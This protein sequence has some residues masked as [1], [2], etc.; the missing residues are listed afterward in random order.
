[1][2]S[3]GIVAGTKEKEKIWREKYTIPKKN[4]YD[5]D[6]FD[7]IADNPD[8]DIVYVVLP[9]SMHADFLD[10]PPKP[11]SMRFVKNQWRLVS[12]NVRPLSTPVK[13]K[14]K[15]SGRL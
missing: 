12:K 13:G 11:V 7:S 5:Y 6:N 9:N 15:V 2:L 4:V 14:G 8:I 10:V 3:A 1:M